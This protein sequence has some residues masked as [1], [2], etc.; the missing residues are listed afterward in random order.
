ML[1]YGDAV[2]TV[3]LSAK[4]ER[5][6][7]DSKT[8]LP[9]RRVSCAYGWQ[10]VGRA[11]DVGTANWR[12]GRKTGRGRRKPGNWKSCLAGISSRVWIHQ[13][14]Y[15][16]PPPG[17]QVHGIMMI[18]RR[19]GRRRSW[20]A[21]GGWS[22]RMTPWSAFAV[23]VQGNEGEQRRKHRCRGGYAGREGATASS[24]I[25]G[26][27]EEVV[28]N[29]QRCSVHWAVFPLSP[30]CWGWG[31]GRESEHWDGTGGGALHGGAW[32]HKHLREGQGYSAN[33]ARIYL[34]VRFLWLLL[35][36]SRCWYC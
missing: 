12:I 15:H 26:A 3:R 1:S 35:L 18:W 31:E 6:D 25:V 10:L 8:G 36:V 2:A 30:Y 34:A 20:R 4:K 24:A 29:Q 7:V 17:R 13:R 28:A 19:W 11:C 22:K 5:R 14:L 33:S 16:R 32:R 23:R 21:G 9:L 27:Q